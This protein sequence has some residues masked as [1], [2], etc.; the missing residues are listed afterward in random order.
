MNEASRLAYLNAM[1]I[2]SFV[3]RSPLP[4]AKPSVA[5]KLIPAIGKKAA[6]EL[7]MSVASPSSSGLVNTTVEQLKQSVGFEKNAVPQTTEPTKQ[8]ATP[9]GAQSQS[10]LKFSL[11][12]VRFAGLLWI[13]SLP[14]GRGVDR[15]YLRLIVA[16]SRALGRDGL[17]PE[18][19][20]FEW[21]LVKNRQTNQGG[22]AAREAVE[23]FV[24]RQLKDNA[25]EQLVVFGEQP[26]KYDSHSVETIYSS[27]SVWSM[28]QNSDLKR[29]V[30]QELKPLRS[31]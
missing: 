22:D 10:N 14:L 30:W 31:Q 16:I 21:P 19:S 15:D 9:S 4:G 3:P 26:V 23:E 8:T 27:V 6:A 20:V 28:L 13:D 1:G 2:D 5:L 17:Q 12:M 24:G 7:D 18:Y 11:I 29:A 25:I